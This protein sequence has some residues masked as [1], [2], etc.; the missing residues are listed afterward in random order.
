MVLLATETHVKTLTN[1]QWIHV[2]QMQLV[3]TGSRADFILNLAIYRIIRW[4]L[5]CFIYCLIIARIWSSAQSEI[6]D[7]IGLI[8]AEVPSCNRTVVST[9][10]CGR[11]NPGSNPGYSNYF[12]IFSTIFFVYYLKYN[13]LFSLKLWIYRDNR[14]KHGKTSFIS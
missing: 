8:F 12:R 7:W 3:T 11:D 14:C 9:S 2:I 4:K 13:S 1:V 10:C 5:F 6:D